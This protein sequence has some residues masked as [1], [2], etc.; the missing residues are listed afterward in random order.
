MNELKLITNSIG[1]TRGK[2][3]QTENGK[4]PTI[5]VTTTTAAQ[6]RKTNKIFSWNIGNGF[7]E[8]RT[9]K[10]MKRSHSQNA[11]QEGK[12]EQLLRHTE[13]RNKKKPN[14]ML[15]EGERS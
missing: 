15:W 3:I 13:D 14:I 9:R 7:G 5:I 12:I 2:F 1:S 11:G 4:T 10:F 6:R 8:C